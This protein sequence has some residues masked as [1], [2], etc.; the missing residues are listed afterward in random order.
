MTGRFFV[1]GEVG[2]EVGGEVGGEDCGVVVTSTKA[3]G[4]VVPYSSLVGNG[5]L[6]FLFLPTT[7]PRTI[8]STTKTRMLAIIITILRLWPVLR[9]PSLLYDFDFISFNG[10]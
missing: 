6:S 9:S 1:G 3:N 7:T 2:D 10:G 8:P 4:G 5:W